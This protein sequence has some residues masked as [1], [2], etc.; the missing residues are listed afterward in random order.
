MATALRQLMQQ[1]RPSQVV[2]PGLLDG[3]DS[4]NRLAQKW[5]LRGKRP[6]AEVAFSRRKTW[7]R[8]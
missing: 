1:P 5:L 6:I 2:V 7:P 8:A 4:V 3:L